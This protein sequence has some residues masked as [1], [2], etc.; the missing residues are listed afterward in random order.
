MESA[1]E[2]QR[3]QI[4]K[5]RLTSLY[6]LAWILKL[7]IELPILSWEYCWFV[8]SLYGRRSRRRGN[9]PPWSYDKLCRLGISQEKRIRSNCEILMTDEDER[10]WTVM[11][12][13]IVVDELENVWWEKLLRDWLI[14]RENKSKKN[15]A[16]DKWCWP[17]IYIMTGGIVTDNDENWSD[18]SDRITNHWEVEV[19]STEL[20]PRDINCCWRLVK[21]KIRKIE[22]FWT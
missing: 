21:C 20:H 7:W 11:D 5:L 16:P 19:E 4:P 15:L 1:Y 22:P 18:M 9:I 2:T 17:S 8:M 13:K 12:S 10:R 14:E 6:W 3:H